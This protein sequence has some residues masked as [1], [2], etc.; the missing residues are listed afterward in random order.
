MNQV[1]VLLLNWVEDTVHPQNLA[2]SQLIGTDPL[3]LKEVF[4]AEIITFKKIVCKQLIFSKK[5]ADINMK[6]L[7]KISDAVHHYRYRLAAAWNQ[8]V[9]GPQIK[10]FYTYALNLVE[11]VLADMG[12]LAPAIYKQIPITKYGLPTLMMELKA[13]YKIFLLHLDRLDIDGD[14]KT[15]VKK[16]LHQMIRKKEISF[17]DVAYC[18][19]LMT[20]VGN[21]NS[22]DTTMFKDLL[23]RNGFNPPEFYLYCINDFKGILDNIPGLHQ[24]LGLL[25]TEQDKLSSLIVNCKIK[26][27]SSAAPIGEQL[28]GFLTEKKFYIKQMLKLRRAMLQDDQFAKSMTR[29]RINMPVAQFGLFIRLHI[30]KGVLLKENIGELFNF[31]AAHFY[32]PQTTFISAESLRKKSTEVE[33]STARKLKA[34]LISM[35][36]WLNEN[37][38]LSNYKGS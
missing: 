18:R 3:S 7:V 23:C 33:F 8:S 36:N 4:T 32:T 20:I 31:F 38:N 30:E 10:S 17:L 11:T 26:M 2:N 5:Q 29:L 12:R 9:Q 19:H 22:A 27:L 35:L 37:Y 24:Q 15:I 28:R 14:L 25:M 16:S 34:N 6:Q 13:R 1:S 21:I